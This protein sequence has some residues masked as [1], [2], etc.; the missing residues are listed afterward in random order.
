V[1][2]NNYIE[3][4][5]MLDAFFSHGCC[6]FSHVPPRLQAGASLQSVLRFLVM[7][8]RHESRKCQG[9]PGSVTAG[10]NAEED[11][12]SMRKFMCE[13]SCAGGK[14]QPKKP[15]GGAREAGKRAAVTAIRKGQ[16]AKRAKS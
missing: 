8:T 11:A 3:W 1:L 14:A 5:V 4:R 16:D 2:C 13:F 6:L 12:E 15:S 9:R 7:C 10:Y